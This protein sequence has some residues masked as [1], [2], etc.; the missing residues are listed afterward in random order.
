MSELKSI[1]VLNFSGRTTDWEGW[2]EKFLARSKRRGYK[3]LLIG[4]D[5]VP[6]AKEY[7]NAVTKNDKSGDNVIKLNNSNKEAFEDIILSIDHTSKHEKLRLVWLKIAKR[8][9]IRKGIAS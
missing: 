6:M 2:S 3:R 5:T 7:E 8:P 1:R 4:K 9:N